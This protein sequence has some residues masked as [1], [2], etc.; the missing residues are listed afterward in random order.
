[1]PSSASLVFDTIYT[2]NGSAYTDVTLEAQTPAGTAFSI[3][4]GGES[5]SVFRSFREI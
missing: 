5:F 1:M 4:G 3:L 2:Y